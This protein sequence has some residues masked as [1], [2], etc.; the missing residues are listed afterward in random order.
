ML[1]FGDFLKSVFYADLAT[2]IRDTSLEPVMFSNIFCPCITIVWIFKFPLL[3]IWG[4]LC[5]Y[6]HMHISTFNLS[7]IDRLKKQ[8][9]ACLK[10]FEYP[11]F[12]HPNFMSSALHYSRSNWKHLEV[13]L[14]TH[15]C[16]IIRH[17]CKFKFIIAFLRIVCEC[18][19]WISWTMNNLLFIVH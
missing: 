2:N 14:K 10:N 12:E 1:V 4:I 19:Y 16:N 3:L 17:Y 9:N 18:E 15:Y 5:V 8:T 11:N 13:V 7:F 6:V